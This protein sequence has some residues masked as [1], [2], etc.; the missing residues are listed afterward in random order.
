MA[1]RLEEYERLLKELSL[2]V[3]EHYQARIHEVLERVSSV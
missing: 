1:G 2:G 3:D